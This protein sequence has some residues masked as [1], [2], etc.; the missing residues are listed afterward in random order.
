MIS[1]QTSSAVYLRNDLGLR[2]AVRTGGDVT[3]E[4][5]E[6]IGSVTVKTQ[7]C[8]AIAKAAPSF[9]YQV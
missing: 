2:Q 3:N 5:G 4:I 6:I 7:D 8:L 1:A 9:R